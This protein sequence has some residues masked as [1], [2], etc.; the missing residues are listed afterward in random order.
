MNPTTPAE[1]ES[2]MQAED[3][4]RL[5]SDAGLR[6]DPTEIST[7]PPSR[8]V[9]KESGL[10]RSIPSARPSD[11]VDESR[12]EH[13]ELCLPVAQV[14]RMCGVD[15]KTILRQIWS[16][17]LPAFKVGSRWRV[18]FRDY[19]A[20]QAQNTRVKPAPI[21]PSTDHLC[22]PDRNFNGFRAL[23]DR[24]GRKP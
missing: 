20:W 19:Q 21:R 8:G 24:T 9:D 14:A 17:D 18:R 22:S 6:S 10:T 5:R 15:Y 23:I 4:R 13:D 11:R 1:W 7:L 2:V 12:A 3:P 16:G